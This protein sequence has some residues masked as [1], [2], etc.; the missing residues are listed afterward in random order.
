M[1]RQAYSPTIAGVFVN[2]YYLTRRALAAAMRKCAPNV[3]G[4]VLDVGCGQKP[5][6]AMFDVSGYVGLEIDSPENRARKQADFFYQGGRFPFQQR[7]P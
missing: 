4:R 6:M 5:Y 1:Q 7:H 3:R 2:P